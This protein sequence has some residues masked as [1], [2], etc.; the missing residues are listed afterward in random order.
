MD[1]KKYSKE[2]LCNISNDYNE[3]CK[4]INLKDAPRW[5]NLSY[6]LVCEKNIVSM[7]MGILDGKE[8]HYNMD[9]PLKKCIDIKLPKEQSDEKSWQPDLVIQDKDNNIVAIIEIKYQIGYWEYG[10]DIEK[11]KNHKYENKTI[12]VNLLESNHGKKVKQAVD[13]FKNTGIEFYT[14]YN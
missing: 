6:S 4:L 10:K 3:L 5:R 7:I 12:F 1:W 8:Y 9:I 14:L 11:I 13:K 2:L